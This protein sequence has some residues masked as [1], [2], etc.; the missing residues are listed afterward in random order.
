[1]KKLI[2]T[3]AFFTAC[4]TAR[5][6]INKDTV[7]LNLNV[8]AGQVI[9][10]GVVN[11]EGL[12]KDELYRNAQQWFIDYFYNSKNLIQDK[13]KKDALVCGRGI[14]SF[15]AGIGLG[16][17][18]HW[19][20]NVAIKIE[21][22]DNKYRYTFYGMIFKDIADNTEYP[23]DHILGVVLGTQKWP[24][25]KSAAKNAL[26]ENAKNIKDAITDL[27]NTMANAPTDF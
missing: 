1:M 17:T 16:S 14:L 3:L 4:I 9:Y 25:L 15:Y 13:D 22:R 19:A 20:D 2:S 27:K 7:G 21:C 12:T 23:A 8:Q 6:Q 11:A 18:A 26:K 5:A 24:Y 10:T